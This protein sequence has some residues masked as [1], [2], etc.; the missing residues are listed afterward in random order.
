MTQMTDKEQFSAFTQ[1][2]ITMLLLY[3]LIVLI[4]GL[5]VAA[6]LPL[7]ANQ[8]VLSLATP[9]ITGLYGLASGAAG[10]W[11]ATQRQQTRPPDPAATPA[12]PPAAEPAPATPAASVAAPPPGAAAPSSSPQPPTV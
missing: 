8:E 5:I 9:L 1:R 6:F 4:V 12:A 11:L 2:H 3:A 10:F 7:K